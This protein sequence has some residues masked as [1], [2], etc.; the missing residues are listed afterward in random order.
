[1]FIIFLSPNVDIE[2]L[3]SLLKHSP[4]VVAG[5]AVA[6]L[7]CVSVFWSHLNHNILIYWLIFMT[8]IMG[9]HIC[10]AL[11]FKS[12]TKMP[13]D[14][15]NWHWCFVLSAFL[16]GVG[17]LALGLYGAF[18]LEPYELIILFL[19]LFGMLG[20][21]V[22]TIYSSMFCF[23]A[24]NAL[25]LLPLASMFFISERFD[26]QVIAVSSCLYFILTVRSVAQINALMWS[27]IEDRKKVKE[28]K[29]KTQELVDKLFKLSTLDE[30]TLVANRRGFN[31]TLEKEWKVAARKKRGISLL[32]IDVDYFKKFNDFYG[33]LDGDEC[34][35]KVAAILKLQAA[36][37]GDYVARYGG[38]E[39]SIILP[40][41]SED[42]S[43]AMAKKICQ[44]VLAAAIEH[45]TSKISDFLTVSVG[46]AHLIPSQQDHSQQLIK[47]ADT[48]LYA[49]KD[50]GRNCAVSFIENNNIST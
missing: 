29:R 11:K 25:T 44:A 6:S 47:Q 23:V 17:W 49:A 32:I 14:F 38:E 48:A 42:E 41:T 28:A 5:T 31:D 22:A 37:A 3:N 39:F 10:L 45:K 26:L 9:A 19:F 12:S 16:Q 27:S 50:T 34:L 30:L 4:V 36:R 8:L 2:Q 35:K 43:L 24:F 18:N 7:G 33:H 13:V 20:G 40:D 46:V 15:V 1:M 21:S